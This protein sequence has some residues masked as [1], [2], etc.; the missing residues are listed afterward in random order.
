MPT[1]TATDELIANQ[2]RGWFQYSETHYYAD[3]TGYVPLSSANLVSDRNNVRNYSG[4]GIDVSA[5]T[6]VFRYFFIEKYKDQDTI[7]QDFLDKLGADLAAIKAAGCKAI[8]RFAYYNQQSSNSDAP[9]AR[10]QKH[11]TQ[12]APVINQYADVVYAMQAG[13][14]GSWGEWYYTGNFGD[15]GTLTAQNITDRNAVISSLLTK[16][17]SRIFI[18]LRYVGSRQTYLGTTAPNPGGDAARLGLHNDA[19]LAP[20]ADYGTYTTFSSQSEAANRTYVE[21]IANVPIGGESANYSPPDSDWT[22]AQA[23]LKSKHW[24]FINPMYYQQTINVWGQTAADSITRYLGHRLRLVS[25]TVTSTTGVNGSVTAA[26]TLTNDGWAAPVNNKPVQ[27][28]LDNGSGVGSTVQF[29]TDLRNLGPGASATIT[30]TFTAPGTAGTYQTYLAI[31]DQSP[32]LQ[33]RPEYSLRLAN[34]G[35]W[36]SITGRHALN[37]PITVGGSSTGTTNPPT[38]GNSTIRRIVKLNINGVN[39]VVRLT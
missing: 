30:K 39:K 34:A 13:F 26:I 23:N 12:L 37:A 14:I 1:Y 4:I 15:Q 17:D 7:D 31:P 36:N 28:I 24:T 19:F 5:R 20:Y 16:L 6:L 25:S 8:I 9:P 35:I 32:S 10:V 33:G 3:N 27:L 21:Q 11:I 38:S 29:S 2:E 18:L 22:N